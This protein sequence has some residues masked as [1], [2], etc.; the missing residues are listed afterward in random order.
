M[1]LMT[2]VTED[3]IMAKSPSEINSGVSIIPESISIC[4]ISIGIDSKKS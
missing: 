3:M 4:K 1:I 2:V